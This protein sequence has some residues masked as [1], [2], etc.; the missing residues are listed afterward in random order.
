M[1][2][3]AAPAGNR[4]TK[5]ASP[6][7][8]WLISARGYLEQQ[9]A[10]LRTQTCPP[11]QI[12][13]WCDGRAVLPDFSPLVD[14]VVTSNANWKYWSRFA[15]A[16]MARTRYIALIDDDILPQP[17][18]FENCLQT[19]ADG[20]DGILCGS[21]VVLEGEG[22]ESNRKVGWNG[23]NDNH[24][25]QVEEVDVGCNTWFSNKRHLMTIWQ[26]EPYSWDNGE[27]IHLSCMAARYGGIS[28]WVPPHPPEAPELWSCDPQFG[29]IAGN[30]AAATHKR[31]D[32]MAIRNAAVRYYRQRGWQL[33]RERGNIPSAG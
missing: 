29:R 4:Q 32:H 19:I 2:S 10:A 33:L 13:L 30:D 15:L 24:N 7:F 23:R 1:P 22:Y 25:R 17:R 12:Y 11:A 5:T 3:S 6:L 16:T 27:D 9:V 18:W 21:G 31:S 26:E 8:L 20:Y 14:R 28:T